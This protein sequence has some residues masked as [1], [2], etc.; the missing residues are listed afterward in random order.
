MVFLLE[1][2][3]SE[4]FVLQNESL[5]KLLYDFDELDRYMNISLDKFGSEEFTQIS[6]DR[7]L[8]FIDHFSEVVE[9]YIGTGE[10]LVKELSRYIEARKKRISF[11]GKW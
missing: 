10:K 4:I 7:Q 3:H 1:S 5:L 11:C 8:K 6:T 2:T 9:K